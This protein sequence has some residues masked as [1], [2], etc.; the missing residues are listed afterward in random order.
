MDEFAR[1]VP[2][3][4]GR[5]IRRRRRALDITQEELASGA[6]I[7]R[8][9]VSLVEHGKVMPRLDTLILLA[10]ALDVAEVQL[11][12]GIDED[13]VDRRR[14]RPIAFPDPADRG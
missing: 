5:R 14:R 9:Q 10:R 12:A 2:A 6:G 11:L 13:A 1:L 4:V 8:S 7:A 3:H